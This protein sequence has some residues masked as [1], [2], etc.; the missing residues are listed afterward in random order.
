M[1]RFF[2]LVTLLGLIACSKDDDTSQIE[3]SKLIDSIKLESRTTNGSESFM[4]TYEYDSNKLISKINYIEN[5]VL[6]KFFKLIYE[7]QIP[8]STDGGAVGFTFDGTVLKK[9]ELYFDE[10]TCTFSY[11]VAQ[12]I[13]R[14]S[15]EHY[16]T[17]NSFLDITSNDYLGNIL[18]YSFEDTGKKGP[19]FNLP[20]KEYMPTTL[21][22]LRYTQKGMYFQSIYPVNGYYDDNANM[23]IPFTNV[24]DTDGFISSST[25]R[26]NNRS[27][28]FK[29]TYVYKMI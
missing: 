4:L 17:L 20:N 11:D 28:D 25:F 29:I 18:E 19:F 26:D 2:I 13:Y 23:F 24:Y 5:G 14:S 22:A 16:F 15:C 8:Q 3:K 27:I 1:K 7:N 9:Y 10:R 21:N 6:E 12:R